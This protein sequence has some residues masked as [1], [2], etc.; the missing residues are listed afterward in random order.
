[1]TAR[2]EYCLPLY[3]QHHEEIG[4]PIARSVRPPFDVDDLMQ[5]V[6]LKVLAHAGGPENSRAYLF[7]V[8]RHQVCFYWHW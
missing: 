6:S 8:A 3:Q 1:L 5:T 2:Q 4:R 7:A